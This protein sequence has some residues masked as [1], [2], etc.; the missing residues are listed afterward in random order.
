MSPRRTPNGR[1]GRAGGVH[2]LHIHGMSPGSLGPEEEQVHKPGST[3]SVI[4]SSQIDW[5]CVLRI[6]RHIFSGNGSS[7][8][9]FSTFWRGASKLSPD[10]KEASRELLPVCAIVT[11]YKSLVASRHDCLGNVH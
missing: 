10:N 8:F 6:T 11:T 3:V 1:G 5:F 4:T 2:R 9:V 7:G